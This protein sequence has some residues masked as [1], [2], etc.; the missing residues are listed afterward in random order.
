V[1]WYFGT[2]TFWALVNDH[3][4][5]YSE[6]DVLRTLRHE[7]GHALGYAFDLWRL[8]EWG[9]AF[10]DFLA[11]YEDA[12]AIDPASTDFVEYLSETGS[13]PCAHYAQKHPDEDWAETFA[14]WL[15]P[16]SRWQETYADRPGALAKLNAIENMI[17][18]EGHAYGE[19]PNKHR[20]RRIPYQTLD[21]TVGGFMGEALPG[22]VDEATAAR[23]R[24]PALIAQVELHRLYFEAL[25]SDEPTQIAPDL[26][27]AL[28]PVWGSVDGWLR[29]L[30][31][32]A[33]AT[34]GW[35]IAAWDAGH[36]VVRNVLVEGH[37]R[38]IPPGMPI[39]LA[40]DCHEH[41]Y[42][43]DYG[44]RKDV[45]LGAFFRNV[46][47]TVMGGRLVKAMSNSTTQ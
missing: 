11:P 34:D 21:Y 33:R 27:A 19:P 31:E 32:V 6:A 43:G 45:Y 1:P 40:L 22:A 18:T 7:A 15:D 44:T 10:G 26:E 29:D 20:G 13:A 9:H 41:A 46:N 5:R 36:G 12:Y 25:V 14:T 30:R 42:A 2:D 16:G 39:L 47:W 3:L 28:A 35:A 24:E 17:V 37:D 4:Y 23:R 38:G 8:P